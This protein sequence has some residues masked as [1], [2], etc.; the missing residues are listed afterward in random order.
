M[1][2]ETTLYTLSLAPENQDLLQRLAL[3]TSVDRPRLELRLWAEELSLVQGFDVLLAPHTVHFTPFPYQLETAAAVLRRF[4][5]RA[6]LGDEVGLG[7]TIEA[8][9]VLKE[10]LLIP[11]SSP[12]WPPPAANRTVR[13]FATSTTT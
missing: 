12:P 13:P 2:Q 5:G 11:R 3:G 9:L 10:Y 8:G 4:R 7:K 6:I 1:K